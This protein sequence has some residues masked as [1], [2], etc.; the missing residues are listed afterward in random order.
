MGG[1]V[2]EIVKAQERIRYLEEVLDGS[3]QQCQEARAEVMELR[4][5]LGIGVFQGI[6]S[7]MSRFEHFTAAALTGILADYT[8]YNGPVDKKA[9]I[10]RAI[11]YAKR[12]ETAL[13]RREN[14]KRARK[15]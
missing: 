8:R 3:R 1:A 13:D 7:P 9:D 14:M 12:L 15:K 6:P 11:D 4:K 2:D 5:A 10:A